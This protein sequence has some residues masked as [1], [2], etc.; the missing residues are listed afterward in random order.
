MELCVTREVGTPGTYCMS[1]L[2]NQW[3]SVLT[4]FEI[5]ITKICMKVPGIWHK[6]T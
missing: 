6:K 3:T 4:H 5:F 1:N 2:K